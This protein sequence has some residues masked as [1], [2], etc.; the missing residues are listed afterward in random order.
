MSL[1]SIVPLKAMIA[2]AL[3]AAPLPLQAQTAAS[4]A[5]AAAGPSVTVTQAQTT[6]IVQSVVVSGSIVARDEILVAPE[7]DGL[8]IVELL[9]EEGDNVAR[10]QVLARL[11]RVTLDV[12]KVQNDAQI[13]RAEAL[14][15]QAKAQIAEADANLVQ[16]NNAFDRTKSLRESGNASIEMFDQR[17]AAARSGEARANSARQALAIASAD[18]ALAQ[19]QGKD[20]AVKLARTEIKAPRAGIVSRRTARLGAMASMLPQT[21]PLFRIIADGAVELEAQVAEVELPKLKLGQGV[22]VT[23]AGA[24]D[25]LAGT[26]RLIMPEVDKA[27]RLGRVLVA[28]DGN[29]PVAIGSFARGVIETGRKR[30][31]TLPLSAITY[32]RA[33]ATV[34]S[35]KDGKVTTKP[36]TLG[37]V[38]H[39]RAEI[40]T[41]ISEGETVVARAG[42]F[43][44]DGDTITPVATN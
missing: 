35:V 15:A 23:P 8:A 37:L 28:L 19:A 26:I 29:P 44:R 5:P 42:T 1:R 12:Q 7:V 17:A 4:A 36:V 2:L 9:A 20:I 6:E 3:L 21:D 38:G 10:G 30:A 40:V 34:Q 39:G 43:V 14:V 13:A 41:G 18:L 22:A 33:G 31:V 16:A 24:N 27:S 25:A 32:N 11:S